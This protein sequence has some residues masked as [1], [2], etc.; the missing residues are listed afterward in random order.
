MKKTQFQLLVENV[1]AG[2]DIADELDT[3][4]IEA[5][6]ELEEGTE[7]EDVT[8]TLSVAAVDTL[9]E[10]LAQ[11]D[12]GA[13]EGLAE[14]GEGFGEEGGENYF[15]EDAEEH[16]GTT[17]PKN[18]GMELTNPSNNTVGNITARKRSVTGERSVRPGQ[19]NKGNKVPTAPG[20]KVGGDPTKGS[21]VPV[22]G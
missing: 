18:A 8:I 20:D 22:Q 13:E 19:E 17:L 9:R 5:D 7:A 12:G 2:N 4:G 21:S 14:E 16:S 10:I 15:E 11:V 3:L 1:E 6:G